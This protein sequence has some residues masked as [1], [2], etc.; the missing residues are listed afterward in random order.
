MNKQPQQEEEYSFELRG[1]TCAELC[2]MYE[3]SKPTFLKWLK[4]FWNEIGERKGHFF[5]VRQ[6]EVITQKLGFPGKTLG[7]IA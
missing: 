3:V 4:P 6:I 5:N 7:K 2:E 1:Y